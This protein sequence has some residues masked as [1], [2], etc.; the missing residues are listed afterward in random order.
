MFCGKRSLGE[1]SS[2][3]LCA[4]TIPVFKFGFLLLLK[5]DLAFLD[6]LPFLG[7]PHTCV[8]RIREV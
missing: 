6:C 2:D 4:E 7:N 5:I 8:F 3:K 1:A